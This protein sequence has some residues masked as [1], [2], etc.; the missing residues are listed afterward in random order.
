M[1]T[2]VAVHEKHSVCVLRTGILESASVGRLCACKLSGGQALSRGCSV[3]GKAARVAARDQTR[4]APVPGWIEFETWVGVAAATL[5]CPSD[6]LKPILSPHL[7]GVVVRAEAD[8][9]VILT[10]VL[11][12]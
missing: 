6:D 7:A 10:C 3:R 8:V 2:S 4:P 1:P 12:S 5:T 9:E 11:R